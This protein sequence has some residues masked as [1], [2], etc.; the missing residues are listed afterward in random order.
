[1]ALTDSTQVASGLHKWHHDDYAEAKRQILQALGSTADLEIFGSNVLVAI[2]VRPEKSSKSGIYVTSKRQ[3]EDIYNGKVV[4]IVKA[5]PDAF[6]GDESWL[7]MQYGSAAPPAPGDWCFLPENVGIMTQ[8]CGD[9]AERVKGTD[10]MGRII[11][12]YEWDGWPCRIIR[13]DA[14]IGRMNR[15]HE[16]V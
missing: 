4:M 10:S 1:M 7:K 15:P 5:G 8:F 16:I 2:Y 12:V 6:R 11:D 9:G 3:V 13:H 14:L